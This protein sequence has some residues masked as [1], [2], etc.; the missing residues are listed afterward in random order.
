MG[1]CQTEGQIAPEN[2]GS[3]TSVCG[4][5]EHACIFNDT[6]YPSVTSTQPLACSGCHAWSRGAW[7][8]ATPSPVGYI[9]P[10][11][12]TTPSAHELCCSPSR[13][14]VPFPPLGLGFSHVTCLVNGTWAEM[15]QAQADADTLLLLAFC[16]DKH[17]FQGPLIREERGLDLNP[18]AQ[19]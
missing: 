16:H 19:P 1:K 7:E 14:R 5:D 11:T 8:C 12:R 2:V 17:T 18:K 15:A 4:C 13:G 6:R 3:I 9:W 10:P